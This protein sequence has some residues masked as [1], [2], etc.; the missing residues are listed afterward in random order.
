MEECEALCTRLAIMV[1]GTFRCL[2]STQHLK[3]KFAKGY[4]L[5]VKVK[6]PSEIRMDNISSSYTG[7]VEEYIMHHFPTAELKEKYEEMVTFYIM[8]ATASCSKIFG[9][10]E[11]AGIQLNIEDYTVTQGSL[12]QVTEP[13]EKSHTV[14]L[15]FLFVGIS[16]FY[17]RSDFWS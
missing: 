13:C 4:I 12:E 5:T 3:N 11:K 17:P 1:N 16:C 6:R 15:L 9:I 7:H 2:G 8:E 10:M 14:N